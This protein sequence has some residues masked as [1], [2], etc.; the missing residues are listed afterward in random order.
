MR[1]RCFFCHDEYQMNTWVM[2]FRCGMTGKRGSY[3][4]RMCE[5]CIIRLVASV[6]GLWKYK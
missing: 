2:S 1:G 5:A 3:R 4:R 6:R